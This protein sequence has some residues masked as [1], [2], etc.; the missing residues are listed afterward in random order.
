MRLAPRITC[1][2][3]GTVAA[4]SDRRPS[5]GD[6]R[7]SPSRSGV[8]AAM[9]ASRSNRD[10]FRRLYAE[11]DRDSFHRLDVEMIDRAAVK[12]ALSRCTRNK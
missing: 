8:Y 3:C 10:E 6:L 7:Y 9:A 12:L 4:V 11:F 5:I 2:R 1:G